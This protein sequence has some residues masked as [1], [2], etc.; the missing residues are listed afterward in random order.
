MFF[1]QKVTKY[2]EKK[3]L[4]LSDMIDLSE[5]DE[6]ARL[7]DEL[8]HVLAIRESLNKPRVPKEVWVEALKIAGLAV[9]IGMVMW[10]DSNEH[11]LPKSLER[12]LS[13][14]HL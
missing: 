2:L 7:E 9:A 3:A 13:T 10:Y 14:P 5:G 11:C 4:E 8:Q 1:K 6:A 12:W